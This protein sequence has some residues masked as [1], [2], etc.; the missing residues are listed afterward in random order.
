MRCSIRLTV[1][2]A[3]LAA[4]CSGGSDDPEPRPESL[5]PADLLAATRAA[6]T[7]TVTGE[8]LDSG[9]G[10][11]KAVTGA[12]DAGASASEER[13]A[14]SAPILGTGIPAALYEI[15]RASDA[16][17]LR[18]VEIDLP[19]AQQGFL[20]RRPGD[21]TWVKAPVDHPTIHSTITA[22]DP[23]VLL[24]ELKAL[25]ARLEPGKEKE[26]PDSYTV[27]APEG[28]LEEALGLDAV[29]ITLTA[30]ADGRL[31]HVHIESQEAEIDYDVSG[32]GDPVDAEAP[33]SSEVIDVSDLPSGE[34]ISTRPEPD[35]ALTTILSGDASGV[36]WDLRSGP[37]TQGTVC[38]Q[39]RQGDPLSAEGSGTRCIPPG[40]DGAD[41]AD[42]VGIAIRPDEVSALEALVLAT[43]DPV[44]GASLGFRD[45]ARSE[46]TYD[47]PLGL[48]YWVGPRGSEPWFVGF[49]LADGRLFDCT[50]GT[51]VSVQDVVALTDDDVAELYG[52]SWTCLAPEGE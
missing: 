24:A 34:P 19:D 38:W 32:F 39:L 2:A 12:I 51:V 31:A 25:D 9:G 35:G 23:L 27:T 6:G 40:P 15:R 4:A 14:L 13:S 7:M 37:G 28:A 5:S 8:T 42:R 3:L 29:S 48:T 41:P 47:A 45:G 49:T 44:V 50:P 33:A 52:G 21:P 10:G 22:H 17:Y 11:A 46:A 20:T 26:G 1:A 18:R 43:P 36:A 30:D 16:A